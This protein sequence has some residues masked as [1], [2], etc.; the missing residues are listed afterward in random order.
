M[1][2]Y[3]PRL[4]NPLR[5]NRDKTKR[6]TTKETKPKKVK[7][8]KRC[9]MTSPSNRYRWSKADGGMVPIEVLEQDRKAQLTIIHDMVDE[10]IISMIDGSK[11]KSKKGYTRHVHHTGCTEVGNESMSQIEKNRPRMERPGET[12]KRVCDQLGVH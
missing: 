7:K 12:M 2:H 3:N 8:S 1:K 4:E 5:F 9:D 6:G 11:H 10:P